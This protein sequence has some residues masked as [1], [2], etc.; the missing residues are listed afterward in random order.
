MGR[1][2]RVLASHARRAVP[3][4]VA[5]ALRSPL[6]LR[7]ISALSRRW[8]L[9][10]DLGLVY[11][12]DTAWD[13]S[14]TERMAARL[15]RELPEGALVIHNG[16]EAAYAKAR[17]LRKLHSVAVRT[18]WSEAHEILIHVVTSP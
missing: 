2:Y 8:P 15:G 12:D 11:V 16:G 13:A 7:H 3:P 17:R 6:Y 4:Q 1:A 14:T 10:A 9:P 18:S 5:A